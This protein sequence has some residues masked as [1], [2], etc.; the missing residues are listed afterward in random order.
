MKLK[1]APNMKQQPPNAQTAFIIAGV[2]AW[3]FARMPQI[4]SKAEI[5]I[6]Q[7]LPADGANSSPIVLGV[8]ELEKIHR[9][10]IAPKTATTITLQRANKGEPLTGEQITAISLNLA[11]HTN[12]HSVTMIDEAGQVLEDLSGYIHRLRTEPDSR[13]RAEQYTKADEKGLNLTDKQPKP[14]EIVNA[15]LKWNKQPLRRD[16]LTSKTHEFNGLTWEYLRDEELKR[17]IYQFFRELEADFSIN[18]INKTAEAVALQIEPLP[19]ENQSLIAFNNGVL[20][21]Q[22]GEFLPHHINHYLRNIEK[23]DCKTELETPYFDNWLAFISNGN[24]GKRNAILAGLYMILTNR[25]EWGLF[26]E[27]TGTAGAG[28]SVF[29]QIASIINGETKTAYISLQELESDKKRSMLIGKSLAVAPDQKPYKGNADELKAITGGDS[30]SVKLNYIDDF[31]TKLTPVFML[32]TNYPLLFTDRNGGIARRRI[33]IPFDR[34]IPKEEKD[35]NFIEKVRREVYGITNLLL[36]LF[37]QPETARKWLE[38]YQDTNEGAEIKEEANH[39]IDFAKAFE[40]RATSLKGLRWGSNYINSK[41][42]KDT[43]LYKAYLHYCECY[44]I[45]ALNLRTFKNALPDALKETGQRID[46]REVKENGIPTTNIYWKNK[47]Q[48]LNEWEG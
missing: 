17:K 31:S 8:D 3:D 7:I 11:D 33:I 15:F 22:T 40:V 12:A 21:K 9:L 43:A 26:L 6:N 1:N 5:D 32:V 14:W 47:A 48:T 38:Q 29:S 37:P 44:N 18:K 35:V 30:I 13:E 45:K 20:N 28:K 39:L 36:A 34:P 41:T 10:R 46:I 4:Q 23:F 24:E 16:I 25:H 42:T 2:Q 27:A 19:P